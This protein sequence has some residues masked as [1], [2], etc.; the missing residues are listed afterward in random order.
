ME[1]IVRCNT[2]HGVFECNTSGPACGRLNA[3]AERVSLS[4][5]FNKG[6]RERKR[7]FLAIQSAQKG[8]L[9]A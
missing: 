2:E 4:G 7:H 5:R 6:K 9:H 8:T 3:E 1:R